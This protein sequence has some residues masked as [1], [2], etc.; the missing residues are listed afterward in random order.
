MSRQDPGA[1]T[2]QQPYEPGRCTCEHLVTL[3]A[4]NGKGQRAACS[5]STCGCR[6]Y[7][8][9]QVATGAVSR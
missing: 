4:I 2:G 9:A 1:A 5:A 3:H 6:R 7:V 8:A